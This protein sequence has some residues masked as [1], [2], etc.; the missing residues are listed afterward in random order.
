MEN[1]ELISNICSKIPKKKEP[2]LN[3]NIFSKRK[4]ISQN[5]LLSSV[6]I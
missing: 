4:Q 6:F 2:Y 1:Y 5:Y 3:V